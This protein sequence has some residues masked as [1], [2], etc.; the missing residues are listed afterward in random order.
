MNKLRKILEDFI[1]E[2]DRGRKRVD[3]DLGNTIDKYEK[4]LRNLKIKQLKL[5]DLLLIILIFSIIMFTQPCRAI[6]KCYKDVCTGDR[7]LVVGG[8]YIG[9]YANILDIVKERIPDDD[10]EAIR[11]LY[12]YYVSFDDGTIAYLYR[13][14]VKI[15]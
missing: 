8:L 3:Y 12:K 14:E 7:V 11:D 4:K 13:N 6:T 1:T 9:N 15:K 10:A 2:D 5:K